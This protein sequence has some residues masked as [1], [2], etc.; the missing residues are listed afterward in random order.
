MDRLE[1]RYD[2]KINGLII[3]IHVFTLEN[4]LVEDH[5]GL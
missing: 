2:K 4:P 1:G 3:F 5:C